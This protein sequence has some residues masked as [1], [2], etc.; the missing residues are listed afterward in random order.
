MTRISRDHPCFGGDIW[1]YRRY[2][3]ARNRHLWQRIHGTGI[4]I[5]FGFVFTGIG[6]MNINNG[7]SLALF[8]AAYFTLATCLPRFLAG[9]DTE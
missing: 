8:V 3:R 6:Y 5:G 4:I 1:E 7:R 9:A 2:K